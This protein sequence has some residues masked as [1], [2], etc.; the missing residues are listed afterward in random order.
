MDKT[1]EA[2]I[3][4]IQSQLERILGHHDKFERK[5]DSMGLDIADT[6]KIINQ[7]KEK[8][9]DAIAAIKDELHGR[10]NTILVSILGG[11]S[12]FITGIITWVVTREH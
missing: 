1:I 3:L 2:E 12:L 6:K 4:L 7:E 8:R 11:A 9:M 10:I 5:L